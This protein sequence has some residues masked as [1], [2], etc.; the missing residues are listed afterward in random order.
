VD[1]TRLL[2]AQLEFYWDFHLWPRLQGLTDEEYLWEPVEGCWTVRPGPNGG[3][4]FDRGRPPDPPPVTTIAWRLVHIGA[5]CFANRASTFFGDGSVPDDADMA[6]PRH[7]PKDIPGT[8]SDALAFLER[9]YRWWH[10]GIAALDFDALVRPLGPKGG[11]YADD[12]MA[13]LVV[14]INREVMHHGGEIGVLRDLY[15]AGLR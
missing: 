15:R 2:V 3:F 1:W 7:L 11:P 13:G 14:H 8:A 9:N 6:D 4:V 10:D 12:P 5:G